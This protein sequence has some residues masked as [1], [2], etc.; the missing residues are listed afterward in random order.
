LPR[1]WITQSALAALDELPPLDPLPTTTEEPDAPGARLVLPPTWPPPAV[2]VVEFIPLE[3]LFPA[4]A[5]Q[6]FPLMTVVPLGPVVTATLSASAGDAMAIKPATTA[7]MCTCMDL[8]RKQ[9]AR[10]LG[11]PRMLTG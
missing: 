5:R 11:A 9:L 4:T 3:P 1:R 6:G 10:A 2:M 7:A 8:L